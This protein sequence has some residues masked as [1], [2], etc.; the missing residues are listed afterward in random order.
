MKKN[1]DDTLND[2]Y[3]LFIISI[4]E[5]VLT[6]KEK[7]FPHKF[8]KGSDAKK[9][10]FILLKYL[11]EKKL[12]WSEEDIIKNI[13]TF[14]FDT[15]KLE[16][17]LR[18][19]FD[20]S[21]YNVVNALYPNKYKCWELSCVTNNYWNEKTGKDAMTWLFK[22]K[23]KWSEEDVKKNFV[24]RTIRE[25]GLKGMFIIS[26]NSSLIKAANSVYPNIKIWELN[27]PHNYWNEKTGIAVTKWLIEEKLKLTDE[28]I[29]TKVTVALFN[30]YKLRGM[31]ST[32][33]EQSS[34]KAIEAA[35]P[36]KF[37]PWELAST[38]HNYWNEKTAKAAITWLIKDKLKWSDEDVK[39]KYCQYTFRK[40]GLASL[41][42]VSYSGSPYKALNAAFPNKFKPWELKNVPVNYWNK[43][44]AVK[45]TKWLV[46]KKLK[47]T[48]NEIIE[49][50]SYKDFQSYSLV[51]ML[52]G[53]YN[54]RYK[55]ALKAAYPNIEI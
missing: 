50:V 16:G 13:T 11:F 49:N 34:A 20:Y 8:W 36:G 14:T 27:V 28:E 22:D 39:K 23:L 7:K 15:Y 37:K 18:Y 51:S 44:T 33:F 1:T 35:Y 31:L 32:L 25:N 9:K 53:V 6:G 26:F 21:V 55:N 42:N 38:P 48:E 45:A 4:Y 46:E 10:S 47:L 2:E 40:N 41:L 17:M 19:V 24:T 12:K 5:E 52:K 29:K 3:N 30:K 43:E 54:Y